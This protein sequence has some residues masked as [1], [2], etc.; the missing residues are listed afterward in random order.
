M[1]RNRIISAAEALYVGPT[2][3]TGQ[4]FSSGAS[5]VNNVVQLNR[6]Q[7]CNHSWNIDRQNVNQFGQLGYIDRISLGSPNVPLSFSYLLA[8]FYNENQLG[9]EI[10]PNTSCI[11]GILNRTE[12]E[13][14]YFIKVASE[15]DDANGSVQTSNYGNCFAFGNCFL[16]SY[17]FQASVGALP[18]VDIGLEGLNVSFDSGASGNN[19]PAVNPAD[20]TQITTWKYQLPFTSGQQGTGDLAIT[21]L[22]PGDITVSIKEAGTA[23]DFNEAGININDA[24]I[25]SINISFDL[26]REPLQKLGSRYAFAREI[27]F[28]VE[29]RC[30]LSAQV[31]DLTTGNL[32]QILCDD[33]A[34][35]ITVNLNKSN[36]TTVGDTICKY[37]VKNA[38]LDSESF[39]NSIGANSTVDV[40]F[41]CSLGGPSQQNLGLFLSGKGNSF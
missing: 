10:S 38:K 35:D 36:C 18:T 34:Y 23:T 9:F 22:K 33:T 3:A 7:S 28:P 17:N 39:S 31:G 21:V 6:I 5:G 40:N 19:I 20:G 1:P 15:G 30:N 13:K 29:V 8:N 2:P 14:N 11:S 26:S 32:T 4:H 37:I 12:D 27:T 16:T 41:S 25:Q 24:K